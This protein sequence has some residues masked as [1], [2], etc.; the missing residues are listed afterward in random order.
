MIEMRVVLHKNRIN[1]EIQYRYQV[2][3]YDWYEGKVRPP[4]Q[5]N[6]WSAWQTAEWVKAETL[7][8]L[9]Q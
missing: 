4:T 8:E 6:D 2:F 9:A 3:H 7:D 5:G 1:P